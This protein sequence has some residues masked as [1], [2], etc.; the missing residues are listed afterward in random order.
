MEYIQMKLGEPD[1]TG[2]RK[3]IPIPNSESLM[4]VDTV[5]IAIGQKPN[6]IIPSVVKELKVSERGTIVVDGNFQTSIEGVFAA[7][8]IVTGA[9]TVILA[10]GGAKK[11]AE[12]IDAYLKRI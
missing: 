2:R 9:A 3:P 11:A 6:P 8:D 1:E 10:M 5:I 7:G 4:Q 12:A